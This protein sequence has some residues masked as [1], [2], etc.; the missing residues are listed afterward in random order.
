MTTLVK[1]ASRARTDAEFEAATLRELPK[2]K[3]GDILEGNGPRLPHRKRLLVV[4]LPKTDPVVLCEPMSG[5]KVTIQ[6][7]RR[8]V[9]TD[10]YRRRTG[11]DRIARFDQ[12]IAETTGHEWG[13]D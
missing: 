10:G 2:L 11:W 4:G 9:H 7:A 13:D 1:R 12:P 3:V 6:L 5:E 8:C